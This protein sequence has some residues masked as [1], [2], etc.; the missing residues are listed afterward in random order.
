M[1][2][3]HSIDDMFQSLQP[4]ALA[5]G[6][7]DGVHIAHKEVIESV[8]KVAKE[9]GL[10]SVVYTF[11]NHPKEMNDSVETPKKLITPEKKIEIIEKLGV[12]VLIIVPFDE[13]QLNIEAETFLKSIIIDKI[14][15]KHVIV[16]YDFR[17]GKNAKGCV[18]MLSDNQEIYNY[19][20]DI[21]KPIRHEGVI[22][23]STIIRNFLLNGQVEEATA[24]LGRKYDLKGTVVKGKQVGKTLGFP[25][26]NLESTYDMSI[27]KPGVYITETLFN[28]VVYP[29][30]TNVGFNPTFNQKNFNVETFILNFN[31]ELYDETVHILF[32]RFIRPE[33]KF[34]NLE[35]L[36][37]QID[38][39]VEI[40]KEYFN[41]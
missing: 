16:G 40:A 2:I 41:L 23:S 25:T 14:N 6:T 8:V 31:Q 12:D 5:L 22:V 10:L 36:I 35:D 37:K 17:F 38:D 26:I 27:L 13:Q 24:L 18:N 20:L 30:V 33:I 15:A 3:I 39:D 1:K 7:F 21:V 29:S 28:D 19:T 32:I 4:S 9:A 11:S 34:D